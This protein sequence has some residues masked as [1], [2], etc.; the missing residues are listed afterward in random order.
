MVG[1]LNRS[2]TQVSSPRVSKGCRDFDGTLATSLCG[3]EKECR[4][5][6]TF[7]RTFSKTRHQIAVRS[8][9]ERTLPEIKKT[10]VIF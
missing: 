10:R 4:V 1:L 9:S 8:E 7:R 6:R 5:C 2:E 3:V